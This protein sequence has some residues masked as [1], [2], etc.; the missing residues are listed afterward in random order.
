MGNGFI[1]YDLYLRDARSEPWEWESSDDDTDLEDD[2]K[3]RGLTCVGYR[4]DQNPDNHL[5]NGEDCGEESAPG[6]ADNHLASGEDSEPGREGSVA[7]SSA[8]DNLGW[9]NRMTA[10]IDRYES[11]SLGSGSQVTN[12]VEHEEMIHLAER[13]MRMPTAEDPGLWKVRVWVS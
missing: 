5:E 9:D 4:I 6:R 3:L 13:F 10:V 2:R 8:N 1:D 7:A 11:T 12:L